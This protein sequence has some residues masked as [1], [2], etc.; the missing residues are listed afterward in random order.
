MQVEKKSPEWEQYE[1]YTTVME[2]LKISLNLLVTKGL[3]ASDEVKEQMQFKSFQIDECSGEIAK[4]LQ[5]LKAKVQVM[6]RDENYNKEGLLDLL[7]MIEEIREK[8]KKIAEDLKVKCEEKD[9]EIAL[10]ELLTQMLKA[11]D[12]LPEFVNT[13]KMR[14][15]LQV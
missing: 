3:S 2:L 13:E 9:R 8:C 14:R 4:D 11:G 6:D 5:A 15:Y 12:Q 10:L 7:Q 1:R